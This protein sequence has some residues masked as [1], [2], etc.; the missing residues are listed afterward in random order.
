VAN[1]WRLSFSQILRTE[2]SGERIVEL[3]LI[4]SL[5]I[6]EI[7]K[8]RRTIGMTQQELARMLGVSQGRLSTMEQSASSMTVER[9][10]TLIHALKLELVLTERHED[11]VPENQSEW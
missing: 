7:M 5:Q 4:T 2:F 10:L 3:S 1:I 8:Q 9:F 11:A 6:S